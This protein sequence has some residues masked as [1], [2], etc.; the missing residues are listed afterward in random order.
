MDA[1]IPAEKMDAMINKLKT[2]AKDILHTT[3]LEWQVATEEEIEEFC[4]FMYINT[5]NLVNGDSSTINPDTECPYYTL[6]SF[7]GAPLA[8][9]PHADVSYH[10]LRN[11]NS[12]IWNARGDVINSSVN[13][14]KK[15]AQSK[16]YDRAF[17][18]VEHIQS[19]V[20]MLTS[21][22]SG[23]RD[24][25]LEFISAL[26]DEYDT[27]KTMLRYMRIAVIFRLSTEVQDHFQQH[28]GGQE[29][30]H[31]GTIT[32]FLLGLAKKGILKVHT[33]TSLYASLLSGN[34]IPDF[35]M[36]YEV[37]AKHTLPSVTL[38]I[39]ASNPFSCVEQIV[40]WLNM[41][42]KVS[43]LV[44]GVD[45]RK[46][47]YILNKLKE[48]KNAKNLM[49]SCHSSCVNVWN[50]IQ[51][52]DTDMQFCIIL[53]DMFIENISLYN[54]ETKS[55]L[56]YYEMIP[57]LNMAND[58]KV[59]W[60]NVQQDSNFITNFMN[61]D[62]SS[63]TKEVGNLEICPF[64]DIWSEILNQLSS[65]NNLCIASQ[66]SMLERA[67]GKIACLSY[68]KQF[69][70]PLNEDCPIFDATCTISIT[71]IIPLLLMETDEAIK[72]YKE[73]C[74]GYISHHRN[75]IETI[76]QL[77]CID[78]TVLAGI[79]V[80]G[81]AKYEACTNFYHKNKIDANIIL[82][83][84]RSMLL[85]ENTK[86]KDTLKYLP[87]KYPLI[88]S[89]QVV[90]ETTSMLANTKDQIAG[91][92]MVNW[93]ICKEY[94]KP[95]NDN[96]LSPALQMI[97]IMNADDPNTALLHRMINMDTLTKIDVYKHMVDCINW[98][99]QVITVICI[100]G[101]KLS[102]NYTN[103][104]VCV[105]MS[106]NNP[107]DDSAVSRSADTRIKQYFSH[108]VTVIYSDLYST[109]ESNINTNTFFGI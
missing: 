44:T 56:S 49:V 77:E 96:P 74:F 81:E 32:R 6:S 108:G 5:I 35:N 72:N 59:L 34:V 67:N 98:H 75:I 50:I 61:G 68:D 89:C 90:N 13:R 38:A 9:L 104:S 17:W 106:F 86:H 71:G 66:K 58:T 63:Y 64:E 54:T 57:K 24:I 11:Y 84:I 20:Y 88:F 91:T 37:Y 99:D 41:S 97:F 80:T 100:E 18:T 28:I 109:N 60:K 27:L 107:S 7:F 23:L 43:I 55:E 62:V 87:G 26:A 102:L 19:T 1:V 73:N 103:Q 105:Q 48:N 30:N 70:I 47:S 42:V 36:T 94:N 51:L 52:F 2:R 46:C 53:D 76:M 95:T 14:M 12:N 45:H 21:Y 31:L 25:K 79:S 101:Y 83:E 93:I 10:D 29:I 78:K 33:L 22:I 85:T 69:C 65:R 40:M 82:K 39:D 15:I 16:Q 4:D 8:S 3:L 92:S